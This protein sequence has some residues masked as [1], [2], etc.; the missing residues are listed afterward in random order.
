VATSLNTRSQELFDRARH[1][2]PGAVNTCRRK[3]QP[4]LAVDR[5]EGAYFWDLDGNR[6]I[7]YHAAYG[8]MFLGHCEPRVHDRVVAEIGRRVLTGLGI[9]ETEAELCQR[10]VDVLPSADQALICNTGSE[11]TSYAL[12]LAR[13]VTG[14]Q[15]ILKFQGCYHGNHDSVAMNNQS[16]KSML[17][18]PD[19]HSLGL[20]KAAIDSTLVARY[21]DLE[22][23]RRVIAGSERDIAAIIIEPIAHNSPGI[24]P[25]P[26]FLEGL[27]TL[28][29]EIGALL[30][31]DE[32]ITGF[33]HG[34]GG[35]QAIC[36][37]LPDI[38]TVGKALGNGFP[39]AAIAGRRAHMEQFNTHPDGKILFAGTYNGNA[40][41]ASA[42]VAV[43]EILKDASI[44]TR[45]F[46]LGKQMR[47]G[48]TRL[49]RKHGIVGYVS[50]YGGVYVLNFMEG[51]L[52]SY[53]DVLRNDAARQ[54]KYRREL[55]KRGVFEMPEPSGRNHISA[56]HTEADIAQTLE[57][58]EQALI[59]SAG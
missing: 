32:I 13:G 4:P 1:F 44:Y 18:H 10:I 26:G 3:I 21:N 39:V 59:A 35:Y 5:M 16:A 51:P 50:G 25:A 20:L 12:R 11:A 42:G 22:D 6:Y 33:R 24:L 29:N 15:K 19:P 43:M 2:V 49:L 56:A 17:G 58:A 31:F 14:R 27:R 23:V 9:T 34:I 54:V 46:A 36:G 57:I 38:T 52:V 30:I 8:A 41:A 55:I 7:D 48:L 37:V 47:D 28:C 45:V 40:V 53:E